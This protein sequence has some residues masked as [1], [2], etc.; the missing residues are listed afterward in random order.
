MKRILLYLLA[1]TTL[2]NCSTKIKISRTKIHQNRKFT[3]GF[4]IYKIIVDSFY[5]SGE[6]K[7][8]KID[9]AFHCNT[10]LE[11][12]NK[13]LT[14][15]IKGNSKFEF[16]KLNTL[17]DSLELF[18]KE[19]YRDE[20]T[21]NI[22]GTRYVPSG[23][24]KSKFF[25]ETEERINLL[26]YTKGK[27][28]YKRNVFFSKANKYYSWEVS[29]EKNKKK[30]SIPNINFTKNIW[31]SISFDVSYGLLTSGYKTIFF[32]FDNNNILQ[33]FEKDNPNDRPF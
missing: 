4:T 1:I 2:L 5:T 18:D 21:I 31:Y 22:F 27:F 20:D 16:E 8:Y 3:N 19:V 17:L 25:F 28:K 14:K 13:E 12:K 11:F 29:T 24:K 10:A 7:V 30:V 32:Y 33:K 6:P 26:K 9:S 15:F 23:I